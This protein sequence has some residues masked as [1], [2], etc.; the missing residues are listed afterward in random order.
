MAANAPR[1]ASWEAFS[2]WGRVVRGRGTFLITPYSDEA[3]QTPVT[4][5][6][7]PSCTRVALLR[8]ES[9]QRLI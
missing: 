4:K 6:S 9:S 1:R 7:K 2:G 5:A 8:F 3:V